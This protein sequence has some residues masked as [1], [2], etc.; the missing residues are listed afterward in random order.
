ML[1]SEVLSLKKNIGK[2]FITVTP[3]IRINEK[4]G[5]QSRVATI[6]EAVTNNSDFIVLGR[7]ITS[8][9]D[10]PQMIKKIESY[11]I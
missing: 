1:C 2:D 11:I 9:K 10:V 3:G 4:S 5:D 7:E 6:E 8:S